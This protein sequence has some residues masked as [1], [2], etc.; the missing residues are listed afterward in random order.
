MRRR[1]SSGEG[2]LQTCAG[3]LVMQLHSQCPGSCEGQVRKDGGQG[4]EGSPGERTRQGVTV[5]EGGLEASGGG[6]KQKQTPVS[7][8][9][10]TAEAD[11]DGGGRV[12]PGFVR[13]A[14]LASRHAVARVDYVT[15][16]CRRARRA[17]EGGNG[18]RAGQHV[19]KRACVHRNQGGAAAAA[20]YGSTDSLT[21]K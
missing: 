11:S 14:G 5:A 3:R 19:R 18:G 2:P 4:K 1:G 20:L 21:R 9:G 8:H 16:S 7:H 17:A 13:A 10:R 12:G 15:R 6:L